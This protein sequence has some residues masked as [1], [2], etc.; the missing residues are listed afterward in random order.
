MKRAKVPLIALIAL[1][2]LVLAGCGAR[3][4]YAPA[5]PAVLSLPD[6]PAPARPQLPPYDGS[7]PFDAPENM[8]ALLER[9]DTLR[10]HIE[11]LE[12]TITCYRRKPKGKD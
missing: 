7:L 12:A 9:D 1:G 8:E 11:A 3:A 2:S 6:C 4:P 10:L 5:P